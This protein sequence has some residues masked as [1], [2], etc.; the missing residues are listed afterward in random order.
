MRAWA[1]AASKSLP[2]AQSPF[3]K[4]IQDSGQ[5]IDHTTALAKAIA[6]ALAGP[7]P[8]LKDK[9]QQGA[10]SGWM[11]AASSAASCTC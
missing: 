1:G 8:D 9:R 3:R 6:C 10:S 11:I 5:I 4:M 2:H 7:P